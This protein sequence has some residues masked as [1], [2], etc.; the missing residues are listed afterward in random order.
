MKGCF[1]GEGIF[2]GRELDFP[3]L[4]KNDQKLNKK[5]IFS[6]ESKEQH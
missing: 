5:S 2:H 1:M 3:A 6:T 4:F